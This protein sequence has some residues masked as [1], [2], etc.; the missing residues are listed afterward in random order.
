ME[1]HTFTRKIKAQ[2]G[3]DVVVAG[4]GPAGSAAAITAARRGAR[5]L[6]VEATGCLGGMG[7]SGL[8]NSFGPMGNGKRTLVG[9]FA[10]E[11]IQ[12]MY[13]KRLLGPEVTPDYWITHYN[14]WIPFHPEGLKWLLDT[15]CVEAGVEIR[16]FSRVAD[17]E[18]DGRK[19]LGVVIQNIEGLTFVKAKT[20][21]D[22]TGDAVLAHAAGFE[23]RQAGRDW[24]YAPGTLCS[25]YGNIDWNDPFY[26]PEKGGTDAAHQ[27][28]K[29][30]FLERANASGLFSRPNPVLIGMKKTGDTSGVLN[31]G[32]IFDLDGLDIASLSQG[33]IY[34]RNLAR[35]YTEFYRQYV[36][37]CAD[38]E[39]LATAPV[40]GTR[41]T[42]RVVGEFELTIEDY[43]A[44]RQFPDQ[45]AVYNRPADVHPT[46]TSQK[47]FQR[48]R[49]L[50]DGPEKLGIGD[51]VGIP[52][53][54][55]VPKDSENI[56]VA[57]RCHSSDTGVHGSIR[58]Q[59]AAYMM[60]EA[61]A[62]AALQSIATG[63]P[64]NDLDT[65]TLVETLRGQNAY[66]PQESLSRTMTR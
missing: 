33:M 59:S 36:P 39:H 31:G 47:E 6:L 12:T 30:E 26:D 65:W 11:L 66:L 60:G 18:M 9:G 50:L 63:Q 21:V 56:W 44:R 20:F 46:D 14:R 40:M 4:G 55:I 64:A 13:E 1:H 43:R 16:Y 5:V 51:S 41:D 29:T 49:A 61:A 54:I 53:S 38:M 10:L 42:R 17:V 23:C 24:K 19:A 58:A 8:V 22:A 57:G 2:G 35:E 3:Y 27:R 15:M 37:G 32:H 48:F 52:Y 34:G 25:I 28:I 7:T 62:A 45:I